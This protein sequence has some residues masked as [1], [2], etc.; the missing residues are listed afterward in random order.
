MRNE[1]YY[2]HNDFIQYSCVNIPKFLHTLIAHKLLWVAK[3]LISLSP[4]DLLNYYTF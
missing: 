4:G 2:N 3:C 1:T